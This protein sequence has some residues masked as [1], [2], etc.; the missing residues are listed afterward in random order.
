MTLSEAIELGIKA[1]NAALQRD[2]ASGNGLDVVTITEKGV[3]KIM[4][5]TVNTNVSA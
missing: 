4:T 3:Q 1:V 2:S 5:K